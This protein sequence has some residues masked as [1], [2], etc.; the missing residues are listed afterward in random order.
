MIRICE[1]DEIEIS[2]LLFC[3]FLGSAKIDL[4]SSKHYN[5]ETKKK[6]FYCGCCCCRR[7]LYGFL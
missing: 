2:F 1:D 7:W 4:Q 6:S 5:S 3:N